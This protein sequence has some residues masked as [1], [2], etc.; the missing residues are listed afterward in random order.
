[1][2]KIKA[3]QIT[4][5]DESGVE[6]SAEMSHLRYIVEP[7]QI[8]E[9]RLDGPLLEPINWQSPQPVEYFI[10]DSGENLKKQMARHEADWEKSKTKYAAEVEAKLPALMTAA[11]IHL[12]D[13]IAWKKLA[14]RLAV[15][16]I[17]GMKLRVKKNGAPATP[18]EQDIDLLHRIGL[19]TGMPKKGARPTIKSA[20]AQLVVDARNFPDSQYHCPPR[21]REDAHI[22]T[23]ANRYS[24][25]KKDPEKVR[26]AKDRANYFELT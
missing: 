8:A 12:D 22:K 19:L 16:F 25:A 9:L 14:T 4:M 2:T 15:L 20:I 24:E 21:K 17:P 11:G 26:R 13:P 23:L 10:G 3:M 6:H 18:E 5:Q 1:M 7:P